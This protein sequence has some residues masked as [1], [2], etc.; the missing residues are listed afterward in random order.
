MVNRMYITWY[1]LSAEFIYENMTAK[2]QYRQREAGRAAR[3]ND[4]EATTEELPD[5]EE[6]SVAGSTQESV[7]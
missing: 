6:E 3:G 4:D 2:A 7:Q 1:G 5:V